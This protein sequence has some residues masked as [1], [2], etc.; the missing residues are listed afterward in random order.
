MSEEGLEY[1]LYNLNSS[2]SEYFLKVNNERIKVM[3]IKGKEPIRIKMYIKNCVTNHSFNYV[4]FNQSYGEEKDLT[5]HTI[6]Y[7]KILGTI[8]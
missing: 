1:S 2:V 7:A 4:E 6:I 8:N 5:V 3:E